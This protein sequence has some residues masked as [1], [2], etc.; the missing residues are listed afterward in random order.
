MDYRDEGQLTA[1][2]LIEKLKKFSQDA[3][4]WYDCG[5]GY[6]PAINVEVKNPDGSAVMINDDF[7]I[8]VLDGGYNGPEEFSHKK[9]DKCSCPPDT[10]INIETM[11]CQKCGK[12]RL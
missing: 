8:E 7:E 2:E 9:R 5:S 12:M 11:I 6:S 1:G 3:L 10:T 4:V